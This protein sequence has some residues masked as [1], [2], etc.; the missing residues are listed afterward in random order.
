M[1]EVWEENNKI[2]GPNLFE[3]P[4]M[5]YGVNIELKATS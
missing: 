4:E 3:V 2:H 5:G 1:A